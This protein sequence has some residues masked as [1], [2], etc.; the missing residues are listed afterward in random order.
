MAACTRGCTA[1]DGDP[2]ATLEVAGAGWTPGAWRG[3]VV[4]D[5]GSP[6]ADPAAP[7]LVWAVVDNTADT[8]LV[9]AN[10]RANDATPEDTVCD[11]LA[12]GATLYLR[13]GRDESGF[14]EPW[15]KGIAAMAVYDGKL[16]V[17][18]AL[19]YEDGAELYA[20]ADG[21]SFEVAI[22]R[23]RLGR[24]P[25][26]VPITTSISALHVSAVSG[27]PRLYV[28]GTGTEEYGARLFALAG[29]E[30]TAIADATI[31]ADAQGFD[32]AGFGTGNHQVSSMIDFGGRLWVAT[33]HF[34]GS[35]LLST[36]DGVGFRRDVG[37]GAALGPGWGDPSQLA[38]RL[39][40]AA[41]YLWVLDV[42]FVQT[43][44]ELREKSGYAF[45]SRDGV[46]WQLVTTHG[47]GTNAVQISQ[48]FPW[49]G[50]DAAAATTPLVAVTS[51][52]ALA[53]P[54]IFR[55]LRLYTVSDHVDEEGP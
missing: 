27:T 20:T 35:E 11:H 8:L 39:V 3:A 34:D 33:L 32:E 49:P 45:R 22:P 36:G 18:T 48:L 52:A 38:G 50:A 15:H 14:G 42:A 26:G 16:Y 19:N 46:A 40:V 43:A 5:V 4:D 37:A 7:P 12:A 24:H 6:T 53:Q 2:R 44:S 21:H 55:P 31:D 1:G 10:D 17:G 13:A 25:D 29:G 9:Q 41:G 47:F 54:Q 51:G 23:A 30:L 28:G